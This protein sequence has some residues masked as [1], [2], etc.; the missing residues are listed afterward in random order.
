MI[1]IKV[2][3][4]G[5][6][7]LRDSVALFPPCSP[8]FEQWKLSPEDPLTIN[9]SKAPIRSEYFIEMGILSHSTEISFC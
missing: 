4:E 1:I 2:L 6:I 9:Y 3:Y 8:T 5:Q 7:S